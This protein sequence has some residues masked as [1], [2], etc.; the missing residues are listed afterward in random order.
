NAL[1]T[2]TM[3]ITEVGRDEDGPFVVG[4]GSLWC[5]GLRI[6]E[7]VDM[8]M[9]LVSGAPAGPTSNDGYE[10]PVPVV[11]D[12]MASYW[13]QV[14]NTPSEW[15]G[16]DISEGLTD[17]Y[18]KSV[19]LASEQ[20]L[21]ALQGRSVVYLANHQVQIESLI[22]SNLLPALTGVPM[23]TVAHMKHRRRW[24]GQAIAAVEAYPGCEA[25]DQIAYFDQAQPETMFEIVDQVRTK[26]KEGNHSLF[27]HAD[28]TRSTTC[29]DT[30]E[31]V[32]S[33]FIDLALE[34]GIPVVPVR[35]TGG[36]PVSPISGKAEVPFGHGAQDYWIGEPLEADF[37]ASLPL[38]D[39]VETVL[40]AI[41]TL[42]GTNANERPNQPDKLFAAKVAEFEA[43][44][45]VNDVFAA[46]WQ[47]IEERAVVSEETEL[48]RAAAAAGRYV[49]DGTPRGDWLGDVGSALLGSAIG[50]GPH[51]NGIIEDAV[52]VVN[53][54]SH[55]HLGD[56]AIDGA[57]VVPV[58]YAVE[59]F[60]RAARNAR[61][62]LFVREISDL[63][64]LKGIALPGFFDG[65]VT[66]LSIST[67]NEPSEEAAQKEVTLILRLAD[68]STGRPHYSCRVWLTADSPAR[69]TVTPLSLKAN[70]AAAEH[71]G[72][73]L[74]H[75]ADFQVLNSVVAMGA[76][77]CA[78]SVDGVIAKA[79]D[80]EPWVTDPALLDGGLQLAL[81]W[82]KF[83]VDRASLPTSIESIRLFSPP[84]AG[85]LTATLSARESSGSKSLCDIVFS[86]V[87]GT[88]V[89]QLLGVETHSIPAS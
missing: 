22:V 47:A 49:S 42:G 15:L 65:E 53:Q 50:A 11:K 24:I 40:G 83:M 28:G 10:V 8:G 2:S 81:L 35:F 12:W 64:V 59:W 27:V 46:M 67:E 3:E 38:K 25:V 45:G 1:I 74:F 84:V 9:R 79:W 41:N 23:T 66:S 13:S 87:D 61:P 89:A 76:E 88:V 16:H 43:A 30:T 73:V 14:R 54:M 44:T 62:D 60:A 56:H 51:S 70:R 69:P 55:P 57:P 75:G 77:G 5:D 29:L 19:R 85:S 52:I 6:Y 72:G 80:A 31:K 78:A 82:N 21:D 32:S 36:L 34:L 63:K 26:M 39:R 48:L 20:A 71:Y 33:V 4:T 37:L 86:D 7:V 58:V 68:L 17:R 18:L